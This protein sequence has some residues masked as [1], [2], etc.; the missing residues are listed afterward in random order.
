MVKVKATPRIRP[1]T[2]L[3][4]CSSPWPRRNATV[5]LHHAVMLGTPYRNC[6][7]K[8]SSRLT[9]KAH[10]GGRTGVDGKIPAR[11]RGRA[12]GVHAVQYEIVTLL[13]AGLDSTFRA[14]QGK[15]TSVGR[16]P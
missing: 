6:R 16:Y 8:C 14:C 15:N 13:I 5:A 4:T 3:G 10:F 2:G 11:R 7:D 9:S 1:R 12:G